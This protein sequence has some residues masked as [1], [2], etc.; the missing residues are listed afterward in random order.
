[1]GEEHYELFFETLANKLRM[2]ILLAV[3][4]EP[5]T[6][7]MITAAVK[8]EQSKVSHALN[9]L[10]SCKL[11]NLRVDGREHRYEANREI[12]VPLL[13]L[14]DAHSCKMCKGGCEQSRRKSK[15][16]GMAAAKS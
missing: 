10:R 9:V 3:L 11:V 16:A 15:R 5:L 12:V 1:M 14:A 2:R 6:V 7:K 4:R 8:E 13:R